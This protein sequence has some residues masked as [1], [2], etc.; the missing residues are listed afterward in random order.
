MASFINTGGVLLSY[1]LRSP[2]QC[3][4]CAWLAKKS[5]I[6]PNL[7]LFSIWFCILP[8]TPH[9]LAHPAPAPWTA[10]QH[11]ARQACAQQR[12]SAL[13]RHGKVSIPRGCP[14][15][16]SSQRP[17]KLLMRVGSKCHMFWY[18]LV[19]TKKTGQ[20]KIARGVPFRAL[21]SDL[22]ELPVAGG[23]WCLVA[24]LVQRMFAD[25]AAMHRSAN[26]RCPVEATS[27]RGLLPM[28][29]RFCQKTLGG[30]LAGAAYIKNSLSTYATSPWCHVVNLLHWALGRPSQFLRFAMSFAQPLKPRRRCRHGTR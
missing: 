27:G 26:V 14:P 21:S 18:D 22:A 24:W 4:K 9:S 30:R 28:T 5:H 6:I 15:S 12:A 13:L 16:T 10:G 11:Q 20:S 2:V 25:G 3:G 29:T 17:K 19:L 1:C 7:N 8:P 23:F